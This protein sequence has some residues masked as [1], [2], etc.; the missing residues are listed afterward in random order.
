MPSAPH[1]PHP[2]SA[3]LPATPHRRRQGVMPSAP[4]TPHPLSAWLPATPHRRRQGV[5]P[6]PPTCL[7]FQLSQVS[8][9][10][11]IDHLS[12]WPHVS[13]CL[14]IYSSVCLP[15]NRFISPP[16]CLSVCLPIILPVWLSLCL[17]HGLSICPSVWPTACRPSVH[18]SVSSLTVLSPVVF[19]R[20]D[21]TEAQQSFVATR[22]PPSS[23]EPSQASI[24]LRLISPMMDVVF[25][26]SYV[27]TCLLL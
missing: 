25:H 15:I 4:H 19:Y 21:Q 23:H 2:L 27:F 18:P 7:P 6:C 3:W 1:T 24:L 5:K 13:V 26:F 16:I 8:S 9:L 20:P 14:S 12:V 10:T 17:L 11:F 22:Q